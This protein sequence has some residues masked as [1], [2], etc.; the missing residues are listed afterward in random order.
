MANLVFAQRPTTSTLSPG[1]H[2]QRTLEASVDMDI[3]TLVYIKSDGEWGLA[4]GTTAGATVR[5]W[6]LTLRACKAGESVS[7]RWGVDFGCVFEP[8]LSPGTPLYIGDDGGFVTTALAN[9]GAA[10]GEVV[11]SANIHIFMPRR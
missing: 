3:G 8:A 2:L 11:D 7:V 6:G 5:S 9:S 4:D 1:P 10:I